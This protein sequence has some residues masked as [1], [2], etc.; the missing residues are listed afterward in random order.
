MDKLRKKF[1]EDSLKQPGELPEWIKDKIQ[2]DGQT[3]MAYMLVDLC[4]DKSFNKDQ[5]LAL[6][7][8]KLYY[9]AKDDIVEILIDSISEIKDRQGT[10]IVEVIFLTKETLHPL[11]KIQFSKRQEASFEY[12]RFILSELMIGHNP[13][14][15][16]SDE[17]YEKRL[18]KPFL[19]VQ[20]SL[21][22]DKRGV[23]LRLLAYLLPYK[24]FWIV[25]GLSAIAASLLA[26][27]PAY[28]SGLLVDEVVRPYQAG[29]IAHAESNQ[30]ALILIAVLAGA[31]IMREFFIW[32]RLNRMSILGEWVARDLRRDLYSHLQ[33]LDLDYFSKRQTGSLISR[34]SSDTERIWDFIAFG[35]VE[36]SI[37][38]LSLIFLSVTLISLD[39]ELGLL[40]TLPVPIL[41]YSIYRH[42][43]GIKKL[44]LK[45]WRKW[46]NVTN[47]L[48]DTIP[49]I[50]VVKAFGQ[51][52]R[53]IGRFNDRNEDVTDEF[54]RIHDRW[55]AFW[56]KL[57][58]MI[59][60]ILLSVWIM[61]RP[62][63]LAD[64]AS[65]SFL[66]VGAFVSFLLY[67]TMFAAP[68]E[69]IGQMARMLNRAL[70]SAY[71]IF[72]VLDSQPLQKRAEHPVTLKQMRG[73]V[74]FEKVSF[75]YDGLRPILKEVSFHV[76]PG[77]MIGL[78]GPSGGGK[79]TITKLLM[80]FYDVTG[81]RI[82]IDG[83][84]LNLL[85]IQVFRRQVGMVL[86]DPYLFHGTILEN[87]GYGLSEVDRN[88]IVQA[89]RVAN[90]HDF[91]LKL[92][93]GYDTIVGERGH[94]LS[95][96]ERQR[97]S[98]ARAVLHDPKIL[99]L[100]EATSAV[101]TET[102]RKIQEALDRLVRGRT[103]F[104]IAHRLS[105]LRDADRL[106]VIKDGR[107]I[108]NGTHDELIQV[109][110]GLYAKLLRLQHESAKEM[111]L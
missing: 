17:Q 26:L 86:Q 31:Y 20:D 58:L 65:A 66:S 50:Q 70:S 27:V 107:V 32:I 49:G 21:T 82:L 63:L 18:L 69:I 33:K 73:E 71:R 89:A 97:I 11:L 76:K 7:R 2:G 43:E 78:V 106:F 10:S 60:L 61:A 34:V 77:E 3:V 83:E 36:V 64:P 85:D 12:L 59:Q 16:G 67:M 9:F 101:D 35:I 81:G 13:D 87:I 99:I 23:L 56:P 29:D 25:G 90:A 52:D 45:A 37:A 54:T 28:L 102:E 100:D 92:P 91:I 84:E 8:K 51:E 24:K 39:L 95:G 62:R 19:E 80:R 96:G 42:G 98:I 108:E 44:F 22:T 103:V 94:T 46:S 41:L 105:T 104:A 88:K 40:M 15:Q 14:Y 47:I 109:E 68:I 74:V 53:E 38:I 4:L 6:S 72:E 111:A 57:M 75:S 5:W 1:I 79:S 110:Q 93:H 48:S 30:K 55:T